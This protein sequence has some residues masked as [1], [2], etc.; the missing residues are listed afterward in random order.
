ML[1]WTGANPFILRHC[2]QCQSPVRFHK[3]L[4]LLL[5]R[6]LR[7]T[8]FVMDPMGNWDCL[9]LFSA[10]KMHESDYREENCCCTNLSKQKVTLKMET[11]IFFP[12][13]EKKGNPK[14]FLTIFFV[15]WFYCRDTISILMTR[16]ILE[17]GCFFYSLL[18]QR[19][20]SVS[21]SRRQH[22]SSQFICQTVD[23]SWSKLINLRRIDSRLQSKN[24]EA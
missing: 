13:W 21:W 3:S 9:N 10:S 2:L 22:V 6:Q 16:S 19:T 23:D 24:A 1:Q 11:L 14:L 17:T 12:E 15:G 8:W 20:L 18:S 4:C 5:L 7:K